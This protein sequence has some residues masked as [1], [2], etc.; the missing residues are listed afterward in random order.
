MMNVIVTYYQ[1]KLRADAIDSK[2]RLCPRSQPI[3]TTT[4]IQRYLPD[5]AII[6]HRR[7]ADVRRI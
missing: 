4:P 3:Y 2:V 5:A 7:R 6:L 1:D